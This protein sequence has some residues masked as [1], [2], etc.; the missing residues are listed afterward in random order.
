MYKIT[1]IDTLGT[2]YT[3]AN[4]EG[5]IIKNVKIIQHTDILNAA[6]GE[7]NDAV[8]SISSYLEKSVAVLE[9]NEDVDTHNVYWHATT[10][11]EV[12]LSV[13]IEYAVKHGYD[14]VIMEHLEL[15]NE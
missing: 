10:D 9:G 5:K 4:R 1:N 14:T 11:E 3:V 7:Y 13:I 2:D 12:E 6:L 15:L 8:E